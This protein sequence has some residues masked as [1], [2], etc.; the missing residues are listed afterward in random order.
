[1]TTTQNPFAPTSKELGELELSERIIR[2][3][4]QFLDD[5]DALRFTVTS[6]MIQYTP[7]ERNE[8]GNYR[9]SNYCPCY[10]DVEDMVNDEVEEATLLAAL[11]KFSSESFSDGLIAVD[12]DNGKTIL[13]RDYVTSIYD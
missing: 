9:Q 7:Y 6:N 4:I 1:M 11:W 3:Y 13:H 8:R 5:C 10:F 12:P 2:N